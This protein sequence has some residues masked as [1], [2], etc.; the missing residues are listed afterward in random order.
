MRWLLALCA[1]IATCGILVIAARPSSTDQARSSHD[2]AKAYVLAAEGVRWQKIYYSMR[3]HYGQMYEL[4]DSLADL[5][6]MSTDVKIEMFALHA[7]TTLD[8]TGVFLVASP[9]GS[10]VECAALL[11]QDLP[12]WAPHTDSVR[13]ETMHRYYSGAPWERLKPDGEVTC[14]KTSFPWPLLHWA[15]AGYFSLDD[16]I[17]ALRS[18]GG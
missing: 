9:N 2:L 5:R 7:N 1:I 8:N 14:R 6:E 18:A 17:D 4:R 3:G 16:M 15:G 11:D 12:D 13:Y 10:G